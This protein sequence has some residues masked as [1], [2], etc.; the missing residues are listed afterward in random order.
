MTKVMIFGANGVM[1]RQ[2]TERLLAETNDSLI[3]FLRQANRLKQYAD[4]PRVEIVDGDVLETTKI[5]AAMV[6][7]DIIYSNVGGVNLDE[8]TQS[9]LDA[10]QQTHKK[11][12]IYMSGLGAHHEVG[13]EFGKWNDQAISRFL[14]GFRKTAELVANADIIYT[15]VRPTWLTNTPEVDYEVTQLSDPFTG[16]EISR[17]SVVDFLFTVI[18]KPTLY[19]NES[20]GLNKPNTDGDKPK[21]V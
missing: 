5:V 17:Q 9:I 18:E 20:I 4:N 16:T 13:G 11:R 15:E 1:A 3:L 6:D 21:W 12:F 10:M 19:E 14:P 8:Q 7:A 2:L